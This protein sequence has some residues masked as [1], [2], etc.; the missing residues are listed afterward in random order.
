MKHLNRSDRGLLVGLSTSNIIIIWPF[1]YLYSSNITI[2]KE[3]IFYNRYRM[4][5]I[6]ATGTQVAV[7]T[8][9]AK[10]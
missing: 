9:T 1:E 5:R 6:P 3:P 2:N 10:I 7:G 8:T 4:A